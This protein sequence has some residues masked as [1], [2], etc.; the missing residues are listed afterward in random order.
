MS[1][2]RILRGLGWLVLALVLA[3]SKCGGGDGSGG[4]PAKLEKSSPDPRC[5]ALADI[6]GFPP[7]FDFIPDP[8]G[9]APLRL[10]A[11]TAARSILIPLEIE[12]TAAALPADATSYRLASDADGD[13]NVDFFK[14]IDGVFSV[15]ASLALVTV[16]GNVDGVLFIDP[17][18]VGP[19]TIRVELPDDFDPMLFAS[20]PGLPAPGAANARLQTGITTTACVVPEP[21]ARD[22][23]G[24]LLVDAVDPV[25][26]CDGPG[27]HVAN[28]TA[29]AVL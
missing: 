25:S 15:D 24:D 12:A 1:R 22:S 16:S 28:F 21:G 10:L 6:G 2:G 20:F 7:G 27:S 29:A 26:W 8:S 19:R 3:G 17:R 18:V 4:S 11:A 5:V 14:S 23:R 13:G 9:G